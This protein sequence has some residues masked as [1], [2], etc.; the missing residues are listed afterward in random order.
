[1][2][3]IDCGFQYGHP[4][5][6]DTTGNSLRIKR[7]WQQNDTWGIAPDGFSYGNEL[8]T[9]A[10]ILAAVTDMADE[11][12][13]SHV[14]GI[15]AG[16]VAPD[17][18]GRRYRGIVTGRGHVP[19]GSHVISATAF[20]GYVFTSWSDGNTANP[21]TLNITSDTA[22]TALFAIAADGDTMTLYDKQ[23]IGQAERHTSLT[24][25]A[26]QP[27][28]LAFRHHATVPPGILM[29]YGAR[30]DYLQGIE[31][32]DNSKVRIEITGHDLCVYNPDD[33]NIGIYDIMGRQ[34]ATSHVSIFSYQFKTIS[35]EGTE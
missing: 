13:G 11:G 14:T 5:F 15:A 4:S 17:G 12:H 30:I 20:S 31:E 34:L 18:A 8:T 24:N 28:R 21:R 33:A 23:I 35:K 32:V 6:Y 16:C 29:L 22:I 10:E 19:E 3:V 1:M 25:V 26:G 2:G 7:V 9:T 27:V